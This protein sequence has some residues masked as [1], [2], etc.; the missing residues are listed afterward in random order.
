LNAIWYEPSDSAAFP[1]VHGDGFFNSD[2]PAGSPSESLKKIA[3]AGYAVFTTRGHLEQERIFW[4]QQ[5]TTNSPQPQMAWRKKRP[6]Q[7]G[8]CGS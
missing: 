7:A 4:S 8:Y 3:D 6:R 2:D 1:K 5:N